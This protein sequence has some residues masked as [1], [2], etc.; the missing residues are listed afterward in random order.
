MLETTQTLLD[1]LVAGNQCR[2]ARFYRDY[3]PWLEAF[4]AKKGLAPHDAE[5]VLHDTLVALVKIMPS[6]RYDKKRNGAFHSFV[7]RIAQNKAV[8]R[9]RRTSAYSGL[10]A[11]FAAEP[12]EMR[13]DDWRRETLN[14]AVRRVF[15]DPAI[16]ETTRIAFRRHVQLGEDAAAVAADLGITVN[17]L[18]Q[19]RSRIKA[20]IA[21]EVRKLREGT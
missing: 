1:G 11:R 13:E 4:L 6:Y 18:Y 21:D 7:L 14:I 16:G 12:F 3:S 15:S 20:K 2:W 8:D 5:E 10:L 9:I 19:I 17:N